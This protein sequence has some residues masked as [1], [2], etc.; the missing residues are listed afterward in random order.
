MVL[1]AVL[2][3]LPGFPPPSG[4]D[5]DPPLPGSKPD[6]DLPDLVPDPEVPSNDPEPPVD[7]DRPQPVRYAR[8]DERCAPAPSNTSSR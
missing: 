3:T 2:E 8:P 7:P 1:V 5:L 6:P 4:P